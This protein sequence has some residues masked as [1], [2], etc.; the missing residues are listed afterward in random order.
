MRLSWRSAPRMGISWAEKRQGR[1]GIP[2][3]SI[4]PGA[5]AWQQGDVLQL[6][7]QALAQRRSRATR[8]DA[9]R[10]ASLEMTAGT[11]ADACQVRTNCPRGRIAPALDAAPL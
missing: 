9:P 1:Q 2:A 5:D 11:A 6:S 3:P 8:S 4:V 10:R 7:L